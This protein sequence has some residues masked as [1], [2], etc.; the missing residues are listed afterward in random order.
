M[1]KLCREC[2]YGAKN[3]NWSEMRCSN[4]EVNGADSWALSS[5]KAYA[6]TNCR[7]ERERKWFA[8]CGMKGKK[9]EKKVD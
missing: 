5:E 4:E 1:L 3:E 9:W 6:G 2:K 7:C 8:V